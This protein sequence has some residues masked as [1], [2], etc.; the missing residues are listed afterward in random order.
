MIADRRA[1]PANAGVDRLEHA[2]I[3]IGQRIVAAPGGLGA[4]MR[5]PEVMPAAMRLGIGDEG[6]IGR[7]LGQQMQRQVGAPAR[8]F[9]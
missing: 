5:H 3:G 9:A 7:T 4:G 2:Q 6:E 1:Q 8:P